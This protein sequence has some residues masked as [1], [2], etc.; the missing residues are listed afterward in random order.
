M[1]TDGEKEE[2]KKRRRKKETQSNDHTA[3]WTQQLKTTK[4]RSRLFMDPRSFR[5][6]HRLKFRAKPDNDHSS[7]PLCG[8]KAIQL[9]SIRFTIKIYETW[10]FK[11]L[12]LMIWLIPSTNE[13]LFHNRSIKFRYNFQLKWSYLNIFLKIHSLIQC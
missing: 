6:F 7:Q 3:N 11:I 9:S 10:V 1:L 12:I 13:N 8:A 4:S 2:K 5:H